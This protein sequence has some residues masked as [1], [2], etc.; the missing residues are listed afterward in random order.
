M[1]YAFDMAPE[2]LVDCVN[3]RYPSL[4]GRPVCIPQPASSGSISDSSLRP[5][6]LRPSPLFAPLMGRLGFHP[7]GGDP[8]IHCAAKRPL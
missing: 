6:T 1:N 4:Q 3:L 8:A 5:G 2:A 7:G